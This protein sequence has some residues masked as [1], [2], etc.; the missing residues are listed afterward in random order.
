MHVLEEDGMWQCEG[1]INRVYICIICLCIICIICIICIDIVCMENRIKEDDNV[2]RIS[3]ILYNV[4][5]VN[6]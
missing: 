5:I 2:I 6:G 1:R 4:K 3:C